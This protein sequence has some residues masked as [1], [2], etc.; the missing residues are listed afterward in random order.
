MNRKIKRLN[1]DYK[2]KR[3]IVYLT[4]PDVPVENP[5][6]A[7]FTYKTSNRRHNLLSVKANDYESHYSSHQLTNQSLL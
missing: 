4:S 1:G 2:K 5:I 6:V 7:D 3:I